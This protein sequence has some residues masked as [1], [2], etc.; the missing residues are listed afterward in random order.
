MDYASVLATVFLLIGVMTALLGLVIL[1]D[2]P[3][4]RLNRVTSLMLF[5]AGTGAIIGAG[6]L[7]AS[8][9][10]I[11]S[12]LRTGF[13]ANFAY[14]W[15]FFFPT[16][17]LFAASFPKEHPFLRKHSWGDVLVY[18]PHS[19]H[20]ILMF[21]TTILGTSFGLSS[22]GGGRPLFGVVLDLIRI[23]LHQFLTWHRYFFSLVN[24]T[25]L[26]LSVYLIARN[27]AEIR[28][29]GVRVQLSVILFGLSTGGILYSVAVPLNVLLSFNLSVFAS[30]TILVGALGV[31]SGTI[32]YAIVRHRFLDAR[33]IVRR[34]ILYIGAS[35]VVV[36]IYFQ[37]VRQVNRALAEPLHLSPSV[38]DWV[39]LVIP[40]VLFQPLMGRLEDALEGWVLRGR[41]ELRNVVGRISQEMA[42]SFDPDVLAASLV[43]ELPEALGAESAAVLLH[44]DSA[45]PGLP[46]R[47]AASLGYPDNMLDWMGSMAPSLPDPTAPGQP[48]TPRDWRAAALFDST[49][50]AKDTIAQAPVL[51]FELRHSAERLGLLTLGRKI[52]RTRYSGEE[53]A[54]I[55]SLAN[56]AG[57]ALKNGL[58]YRE[59][60]AKAMI[61]E[62][63][64]VA[65]KIQQAFLP[66]LFPSDLPVE[67]HGLNLPS[68][69]VGGD[70]FDFFPCNG[71]KYALAIADV[72]GKGVPAAL[73]ATMLQASL[74]TLLRDGTSVG[75]V[76][77]RVNAMLCESTSPDQFV[78]MFLGLVDPDRMTITY[79]NAGHNYP[80]LACSGDIRFLDDSELVLGIIESTSYPEREIR[81]LEGDSLLLYTDG[82]IEARRTD[83]EEYGED[84]LIELLRDHP[85]E[86]S[87]VLVERIRESV[88]EFAR[89]GD[90]QDDMT[91]L[92]LRVPSR[93][94]A[95]DGG[96]RPLS[97][98]HHQ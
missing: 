10:A 80:I 91:L 30:S 20:F 65:R 73:L 36:G 74:R 43:R 92:C 41:R 77:E 69:Q 95:P 6:A 4:A 60:L 93:L 29:A 28:S 96:V 19:I 84:R 57:V 3:G 42:S 83:G 62:E 58:L 50:A 94:T 11:S 39:A 63:L 78:T 71:G 15:E 54:I 53:V 23:F 26:G 17:L 85:Q 89:P 32:A 66:S 44:P 40:L 61:E 12:P 9:T 46:Y 47:V 87:R 2:N 86:S 64:A 59:T 88:L 16:L 7:T 8:R 98:G 14:L 79:C 75:P 56:Q 13:A 35:A 90:V 37:V 25:Y 34:T 72:A 27:R 45:S 81:M 18:I 68:K 55:G 82:V 31:C 52:S 33:W 97:A 51:A 48:H 76:C 1:R 22:V 5:F 67:V 49:D 21:L 24:L 70:Y 38:L